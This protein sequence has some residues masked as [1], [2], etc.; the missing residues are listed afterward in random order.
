MS[1]TDKEEEKPPMNENVFWIR[2]WVVVAA[3][4]IAAIA[5]IWDSYRRDRE[6]DRTAPIMESCVKH[7]VRQTV[8]VK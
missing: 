7:N 1:E 4:A 6:F 2:F 8:T 3:V 5:A